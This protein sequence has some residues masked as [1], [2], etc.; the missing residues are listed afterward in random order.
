M[1]VNGIELKINMM[2]ASFT[3]RYEKALLKMQED[4]KALSAASLSENIRGQISCIKAFVDGVFGEGV[5]Q[6][7]KMDDDDLDVN[8][9]LVES[10]VDETE[11]QKEKALHRF[12]KYSPNRSA[13]REK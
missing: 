7:L 5:Y 4:A 11:I 9:D 12:D 1:L 13:R 3:E 8:L 6:S 2:S 10:I